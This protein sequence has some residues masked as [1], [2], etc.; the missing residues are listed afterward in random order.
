LSRIYERRRTLAVVFF[1]VLAATVALT[2]ATMSTARADAAKCDRAAFADDTGYL[3]C[4]MGSGAGSGGGAANA[5][6]SSED[7]PVTGNN[8]VKMLVIGSALVVV[9]GAAVVGSMQTKRR[10]STAV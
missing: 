9:G 6:T 4:L 8:P 5:E 2:L 3:Q 7:L 1:A 10:N